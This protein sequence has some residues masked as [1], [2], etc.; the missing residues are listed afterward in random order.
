[1]GRRL[2]QPWHPSIWISARAFYF[3]TGTWRPFY[4][5][6]VAHPERLEFLAYHTFSVLTFYQG[7]ERAGRGFEVWN[8]ALSGP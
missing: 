1:M 8:G 5:R 3:N 2:A 7:D 6:T 4:R